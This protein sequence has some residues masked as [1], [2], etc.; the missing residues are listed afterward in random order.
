MLELT[1]IAPVL[2][3]LGIL[4]WAL[5]AAAIAAALWLPKKSPHKAGAALLV[6]GVFAVLPVKNWVE[7]REREAYAQA[8][9]AHFRKLC[10]EKAGE[11]IYKTFT[12]VKSVLVVKPL[13]PAT[14][15]DLYD[16]YWMGDPFSAP[17]HSQRGILEAVRM[18][19]TQK[20]LPPFEHFEVG[21]DFVELVRGDASAPELLVLRRIPDPPYWSSQPTKAQA[22]QFGIS[23]EDISTTED[24]R[25]WIAGS[26]LA[27]LDLTNN[28]V[29]AERIGF[30]IE[31]GLGS[32]SGARRPW[33]SSRGPRT[34]CPPLVNGD[35]DD[36][37]FVLK[38]LRPT[39]G[40]DNG[41]R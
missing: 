1:G 2:R 3:A 5:A 11:K 7:H 22:S 38:V 41:K 6:A 33:L 26:R 24:R 25:Y 40:N 30:F 23:W 16:Q 34:T 31:A 10:A 18:A 14:E 17:A 27:I 13:P 19:G 12:G 15:K 4:Y 28:T 9:W 37:W 32:K 20:F 39:R 35:Y 36:R 21:F 29:V 8:A